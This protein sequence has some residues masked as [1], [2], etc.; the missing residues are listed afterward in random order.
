MIEILPYSE[1]EI[2]VN[3][4]IADLEKLKEIERNYMLR[5]FR[6]GVAKPYTILRIKVKLPTPKLIIT[7]H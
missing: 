7:P 3:C 1:K 5:I 2:L 6:K 4:L